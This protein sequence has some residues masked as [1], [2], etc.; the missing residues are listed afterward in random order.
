MW[1]FS[2]TIFI[3]GPLC[4][5]LGM[6]FLLKLAFFAHLLGVMIMII[7][8]GFT[9]LF[10]GA[11]ILAMGN[12]LVEAAA[13][14]LVATLYPDNK[15]EMLNKFHVWFP[16]GIVIGG[17]VSFGLDSIGITGYQIKLIVILLPTLIYGW[18][19]FGQI[20]SKIQNKC[21]LKGR[22]FFLGQKTKIKTLKKSFGILISSD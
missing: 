13:N 9:L 22:L 11:L 8:N 14:P 20:F 1:G 10:I 4:D 19:F 7:A 5:V 15:T 12:G 6:K 16:G 17:L 3:F 18:L 21:I 2:I